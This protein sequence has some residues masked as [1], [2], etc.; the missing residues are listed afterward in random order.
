MAL[1]KGAQAY[2]FAGG[3]DTKPAPEGVSPAHL[4]ALENGVF[5][6]ATSI[7][8]RYGYEALPLALDGS[9]TDLSGLIRLANRDDELL[10]FTSSACYSYEADAE[11]W[12][13]VGAVFSVVGSDQPVVRTGTEQT[14]PDHATNGGVTVYAWEDS[15][16]G[17]YYTVTDATS[18]RIHIAPTQADALATAPRCVAV[19]AALHIY[20][21]VASLGRIYIVVVNPTAPS[22][23]VTP[24]ILVDDL[25]ASNA[26]YD[27]CPT[28]RTGT[29]AL[30]AWHENASTNIRIGYVDASG[31][32]GSPLTGHP[33][34]Y[35]DTAAVD[36]AT[37]IAIA[38]LDDVPINSDVTSVVFIA[39]VNG[40]GGQVEMLSAGGETSS[41]ALTYPIG[42]EFAIAL[43]AYAM[44]AS[45]QR[46]ALAV[47]ADGSW[48]VWAAFEEYAA[49][50]SN[51]YVVI[52][53]V[54]Y[55]TALV[56]SER[57]QRSV[58]LASRAFGV[59][60]DV[61][62]YF[63]HDTTYF[64]VYLAL[65]LSDSAC[66]ARTLPGGAAAA[67]SRKHL[68]S[69]H[70]SGDAVS[71]ALAYRERVLSEN[72]DKFTETG[73]RRVD[74]D[75]GNSDSHQHAQLGRGLYLGGACPQ[76]YDG[77]QW[78]EQGFHVGPE[79]IATANGTSG[80][81]T[82]SSTYLYRVWY[83]WTDAQGEVHRGPVSFGT[84]ITLG[85]GGT[86]DEVVLTLP[87]LR[88]TSKQN[89]RI[90]VARSRAAETGST[91]ELFR[92]TSYDPS[93]AG[94]PNGYVANNTT[95]N[96]VIFTDRMSD[97]TLVTQEPLYTNGGIL[98]TDPCAL[99]HSIARGKNRL[100]ATDPSNPNRVRFSQPIQDGYGVEFP[101]E[102][103][104]DCDPFGGDVTA[105]SVGEN[106][107]VIIFKRAAAFIF[108]GDGPL[109][110]GDT[111]TSGFSEPR[112][113]RSP[114]GC[115]APS[116]I[117]LTP[118]GFMFGSAQGLWMVAGDDQ[119]GYVGAP[120]EAYNGQT[121]TAAT[122]LPDRTQVV[123][124]TD[125]GSALLYDYLFGQ[126]STFTNH[127]GL[128]AAVVS[129][130]YHYLR[131]D[132]RVYRETVGSYSDD[133]VRIRLR[134]ETAWLH[135]AE[136]IQ[137]FQRFYNL[138]LIG[139]WL[140][141]HQLAIS[142]RVDYAPGQLPSSEPSA[143]NEPMYLDATGE[144][145][146]TGWISGSNADTIGEDSIL[147]DDYGD[148]LYGSGDY[149]DGGPDVYQWRY[150]IGGRGQSVQFRFEDYER[151][152]LTPGASFELTEML[153]EGG[154]AG[155]SKKPFSGAR[156]A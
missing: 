81:L 125:S 72:N 79:N 28:T 106:G 138:L 94:T 64:N 15:R 18:G 26:V 75:F 135:V 150:H 25:N 133:G 88:V 59:G 124:L 4:L 126:W 36:P 97:A 74:L 8:K 20:Y 153:I 17:V 35:R 102:L 10:G 32:L 117:V 61:F 136:A 77:R 46:I 65:R 47:T 31:V 11:Q 78:T 71:I 7:R 151:A 156:S 13:S 110:N 146:S 120:V 41:T 62:A 142:H 22:A 12:S 83:E 58:G 49:V 33:G 118:A 43:T 96:A 3:I 121:I 116:S 90:C 123:F 69:A 45:V 130:T 139:T 16:G 37:P 115:T 52:N 66:V 114:V 86:E 85:G 34:V 143:W 128:D 48:I 105:L 149:G 152:G 122:V 68:P 113:I 44:P 23:T 56:G 9:A 145:S 60:G 127:E 73:V 6:R 154:R 30:I 132:G 80:S 111:S 27:A 1:A 101:P 93:T 5:T 57:T 104:I 63:V 29:P 82:P 40:S 131:T 155:T 87:T 19:G 108:G 53:S 129:N 76:H 144:A 2:R 98:S 103:Y 54:D 24:S 42:S 50:S 38:F 137:G 84:L 134:L 109:E 141:P 140:S 119:V 39:Y 95:V 14:V 112:R 92:V 51:R 55:N 107:G 148:G 99:G 67:S 21:A 147:G 89:V 70:V 91:A 100:F